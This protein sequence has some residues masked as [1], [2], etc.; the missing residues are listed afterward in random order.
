M[1]RGAGRLTC[2][3]RAVEGHFDH[4]HGRHWMYIADCIHPHFAALAGTREAEVACMGTLTANLHLMMNSFYKP[5]QE[6][7]RILC[8][9]RAFPSDQVPPLPPRRA[10][11]P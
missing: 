10:A 5:T 1:R 4:P 8:E 2:A 11:P 9:G 6:R 3:C 7:Y